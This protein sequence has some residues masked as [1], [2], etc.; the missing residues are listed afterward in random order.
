MANVPDDLL[1]ELVAAIRELAHRLGSDAERE[2]VAIEDAHRKGHSAGVE[3]GR[4]LERM[5]RE[6]VDPIPADNPVSGILGVV[7]YEVRS[8]VSSTLGRRMVRFAVWTALGGLAGGGVLGGWT[9]GEEVAAKAESMVD[10][11]DAE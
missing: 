1:R 10:V 9:M 5:A 3:E 2:R 8:A 11:P 6:A 7:A 4:R